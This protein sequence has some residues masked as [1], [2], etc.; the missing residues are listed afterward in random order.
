MSYPPHARRLC[1]AIGRRLALV[2]VGGLLCNR[3]LLLAGLAAIL[4]CRASALWDNHCFASTGPD[5]IQYRHQQPTLHQFSRISAQ[6]LQCSRRAESSPGCATL[7]PFA[8]TSESGGVTTNRTPGGG[9]MAAPPAWHR[10]SMHHM[11]QAWKATVR[12][13]FGLPRSEK[14]TLSHHYTAA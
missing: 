11:F 14:S 12:V 2:L 13:S 1:R 9:W 5:C 10:N 4:L 3:C 8:R 7:P 6:G